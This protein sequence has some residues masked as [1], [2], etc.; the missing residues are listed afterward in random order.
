MFGK[1]GRNGQ[2]QTEPGNN[3]LAKRILDQE[4]QQRIT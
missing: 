3:Q 1:T 4:R 2:R